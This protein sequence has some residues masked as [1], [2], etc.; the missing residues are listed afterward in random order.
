M[1]SDSKSAFAVQVEEALVRRA[2]TGDR[3]ALYEIYCCFEKPAYTLAYRL[4]QCPDRARD[5][6]Q[7]GMLS[8]VESISQFRFEAP[9]WA[10]VRRL[11]INVALMHLRRS[12]RT[13]NVEVLVDDQV[14]GEA[15]Q[16]DMARD[17]S[18]AFARLAPERRAVLW[19]YSV[20]GY[21]HQEIGRMMGYSES[22]SKT[23]L[24]RA[25][26]QVRQWWHRESGSGKT[27][28]DIIDDRQ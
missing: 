25:R 14:T 17:L 11:F 7:D 20:E 3:D 1:R 16:A 10:W 27:R 21:S 12:H 18:V 4:V 5:I 28:S 19:L 24:M 23:Q 2:Q 8:L 9:F 15:V 6:R 26:R 22:Y 13:D